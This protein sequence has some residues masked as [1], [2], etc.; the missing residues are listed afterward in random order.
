MALAVEKQSEKQRHRGVWSRKRRWKQQNV[1]KQWELESRE[2]IK[3]RNPG[4]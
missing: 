1:G 3:K 4:Y 2:E